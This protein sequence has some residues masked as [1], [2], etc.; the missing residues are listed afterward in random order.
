MRDVHSS[1]LKIAC[2]KYIIVS[3]LS[4]AFYQIPLARRSMKHYGVVTLFKGVRVCTRCAM[5]IPGSETALEE[6]MCRV[7]GDLLK[8]GCITK[9]ADDLYCGGS[10]PQELLLNW[11]RTLSAL[12]RCNLRL[13]AVLR[14]I[15]S[16]QVGDPVYITSDASKTRAHD[17][18]LVVSDDSLWCNVHK[19]VGSQLPSISYRIKL[20]ECYRV[21]VLADPSSKL[22]RCY[23]AVPYPNG[24]DTEEELA[25]TLAS[26]SPPTVSS[27][28]P[29]VLSTPPVS[30][31]VSEELSLPSLFACS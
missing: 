9:I 20:S 14:T 22:P 3:N 12:D 24:F 16:V 6:L 7:L 21:P 15:L 4:Q 13:S 28:A 19:F 10:T 1:L 2:W 17:R 29:D 23:S 8:G 11:R 18:Y 5:G 25:P 30:S 31:L 26:Q 27:P